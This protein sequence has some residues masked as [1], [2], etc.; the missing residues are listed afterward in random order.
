[1]IL[2]ALNGPERGKPHELKQGDN[3]VGRAP[4][5]DVV[6]L[7]RAVSSSHLTLTLSGDTV[8]ARDHSKNGTFVNDKRINEAQL[9]SGD[10]IRV[11]MTELQLLVQ[12]AADDAPTVV[13]VPVDKTEPRRVVTAGPVPAAAAR[14]ASKKGDSG[15]YKSAVMPP[16]AAKA[17]QSSPSAHEKPKQPP[18]KIR[19]LLLVGAPV[20]LV[21]IV[22]MLWM[23]S[24]KNNLPGKVKSPSADAAR[25]QAGR[26]SDSVP[27]GLVVDVVSTFGSINLGA[28]APEVK[29]ALVLGKD[30]YLRGIPGQ[31]YNAIIT[32]SGVYSKLSGAD[33]QA[34]ANC[35]STIERALAEDFKKDS[36]KI[37]ILVKQK[38][39]SSLLDVLDEVVGEFPV[40][41]E[42]RHD[43]ASRMRSRYG[44]HR[45]E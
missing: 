17:P 22:A 19:R 1:M 41:G 6:V 44:G 39:Y 8:T 4:E 27:R 16:E 29:A 36:A 40:V 45:K 5:N 7:D 9:Q 42:S 26:P 3:R 34:L 24:G 12:P 30:Q 37:E 11:G 28:Y 2:Q 13:A 33:A 31:R 18:N 35:I 20:L 25:P 15:P 21:M 23:D 38:N 14:P 32:W 43:W 10:R